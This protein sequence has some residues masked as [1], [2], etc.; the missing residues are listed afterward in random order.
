MY[1]GAYKAWGLN[2]K[3]YKDYLIFYPQAGKWRKYNI[4]DGP[5]RFVEEA[6]LKV[7]QEIAYELTIPDWNPQSPQ[8]SRHN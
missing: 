5:K 6:P 8:F 3:V 2:L 4:N 7:V 1:W